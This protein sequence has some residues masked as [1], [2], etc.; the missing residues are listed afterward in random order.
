MISTVQNLISDIQRAIIVI[1]VVLLVVLITSWVF[2]M[3]KNK[4]IKKKKAEND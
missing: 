1:I 4:E 2:T 3:L